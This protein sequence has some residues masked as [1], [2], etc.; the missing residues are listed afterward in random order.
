MRMVAEIPNEEELSLRFID[1]EFVGSGNVEYSVID[2]V[3]FRYC[4]DVRRESSCAIA[5]SAGE[6]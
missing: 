1:L 3:R 4:H 2:R 5:L 6:R